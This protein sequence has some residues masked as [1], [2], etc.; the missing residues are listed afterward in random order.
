MQRCRWHGRRHHKKRAKLRVRHCDERFELDVQV[1]C[2]YPTEG[3]T[4][5]ANKWGDCLGC[6]LGVSA[7]TAKTY[8]YLRDLSDT[9]CQVGPGLILVGRNQQ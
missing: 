9:R 1:L 5:K 2:T 7:V 6:P 4:H 3:A 8:S